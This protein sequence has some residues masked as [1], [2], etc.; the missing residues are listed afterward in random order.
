VNE[1]WKKMAACANQFFR[2]TGRRF[3]TKAFELAQKAAPNTEL[4]YNDY[5]IEQPKKRAGAIAL[6]K[7]IQAA[8]FV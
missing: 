6:I 3:V 7:K 8:G 1:A 2:K 5:N 4:Y